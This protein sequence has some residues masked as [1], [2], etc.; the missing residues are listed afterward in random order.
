MA[1]CELRIAAF[2]PRSR[3]N[4]PGL[5]SVLWVQGCPL[6]CPGC[7]NPDFLPFEG[8]LVESVASFA[9]RIL[10][11]PDTEGVS[12]SGGE[13]FSQAAPLADL[14]ERVRA[15]GKGVLIFTGCGA[16][17]L[18]ARA[19]IGTRRLLAAADLLVAGPYRQEL[20]SRHPLLASA[21]QELVFLTER[22]RGVDLGPRRTEIRIAGDGA[23]SMTGFP[24]VGGSSPHILAFPLEGGRDDPGGRRSHSGLP[25]SGEDRSGED[26]GRACR[27][28]VA[29]AFCLPSPLVGEGSGVGGQACGQFDDLPEDQSW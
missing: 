13:P 24:S 10:S 21:N 23:V 29:A 9:D 17:S 18:T 3:T 1:G 4:G 11:D 6:R 7:F 15:A 5:R 2:L 14:A 28:G 27:S 22:Y 8:G 20:S 16:A 12:F 25:T 19:D 26:T